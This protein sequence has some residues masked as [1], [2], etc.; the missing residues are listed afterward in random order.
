MRILPIP[1]SDPM[2]A[3]LRDGRKTQTRRV[4]TR[5]NTFFNGGPWPK[6]LQFNDCKWATAWVDGGPSPAGNVGPYLHVEWPYGRVCD[7][8]TDEVLSARIYPKIQPGDHLYVR[9]TYYQFGHWEP[10][11]GARTKG[12]KQK[13][14]FIADRP[15]VLFEQPGNCRLGHRYCDPWTP[16]WHKRL[17][18]FMPKAFSRMTLIVTDVRVQRLHEISEEDAI[19]EG[20]LNSGRRDGEPWGHFSVPGIPS[21]HEHEASTCYSLLWESI[22]GPGAWEA[23]PWVTATTFTVHHCNVDQIGEAA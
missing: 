10:V 1:F 13:W 4:V 14:A 17:G 11:Q 23:N 15:D 16:A 9:E 12:G 6:E 3:A 19:A 7:G 18:R 22:N 2:S 21:I 5:E 20:V 8:G